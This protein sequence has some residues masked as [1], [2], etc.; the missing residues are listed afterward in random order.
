MGRPPKP[1]GEARPY[2]LQVRLNDAE[3][4]AIEKA[5]GAEDV[6]TW[7]RQTLLRI[8]KRSRGS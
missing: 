5:A 8:A 1:E 6:S 3:R 7:A 2:R 4:D